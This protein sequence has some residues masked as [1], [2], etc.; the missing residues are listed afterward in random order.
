MINEVLEK[1]SNP[2]ISVV[3]PV[4]NCDEYLSMAIDSIL[5]QTFRNFEIIVIND[6][7]TDLSKEII[8]SYAAV[9]QRIK[10]S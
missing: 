9:D 6:G 2:Y 4:F 7:S 1:H 8:D 3:L 5:S 10:S